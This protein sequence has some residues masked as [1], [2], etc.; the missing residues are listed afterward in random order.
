MTESARQFPDRTAAAE[1]A[2][3]AL[4]ALDELWADLALLIVSGLLL[5]V[6]IGYV[7]DAS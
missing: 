4:R 5:A 1:K 7:L 3:E 6:A 2:K